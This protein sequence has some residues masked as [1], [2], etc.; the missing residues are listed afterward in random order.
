M[1]SPV[2]AKVLLL[3][4]QVKSDSALNVLAESDPVMIL[5]FALL[6]IVVALAAP[7]TP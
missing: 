4:S 1:T 6:L 3:L 2:T 5:L 7:W